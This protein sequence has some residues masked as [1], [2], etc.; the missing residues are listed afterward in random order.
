MTSRT[1]Q[2]TQLDLFNDSGAVVYAN[3]ALAALHKRDATRAADCIRRIIDEEPGYCTLGALQTLCQAVQDW[4]FPCSNPMELAEAIRRLEVQVQ[5]AA[6]SLMRGEAVNFIRPYWLELANAAGSQV[7]DAA[8]PQSFCAGLYIRCEDGLSAI[9]AVE[10]VPNWEGIPD[11]LHLLCLARY[12]VGGFNGCQSVLMR[13]AF[14]SPQR[15]S[16][17]INGMGDA[18]IRKDWIAF[19]SGFDWLDPDDETMGA[20]FP[21]WYLLEHTDSPFAADAMPVLAT[22]AVR[23]FELLTRII[24]LEKNGLST[25]LVSLRKQLRGLDQNVFADYMARRSAN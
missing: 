14:L 23:V 4:P 10:S 1:S 5:P 7:Y 25:A 17:T 9:K 2:T 6:E 11:L 13:L 16:D 15:L 3:D 21:V 19:K 18:Q 8:F 22:A 20:W 24:K 12:R